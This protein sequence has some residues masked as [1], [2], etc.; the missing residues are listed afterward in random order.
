MTIESPREPLKIYLKK[1]LEIVIV[2][3]SFLI[4]DPR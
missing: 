2:M 1:E 4:V 3:N